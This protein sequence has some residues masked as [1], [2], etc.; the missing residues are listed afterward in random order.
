MTADPTAYALRVRGHLDDHWVGWLGDVT[1]TAHADGT[2]TI[3]GPIADQA[4]LHGLLAKVRDLG[5]TLLAVS[6]ETPAI[7]IHPTPPTS[8]E[9]STT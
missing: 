4:E 5:I 9:R 1:V 8:P 2:S 6:S 3:T 7:D